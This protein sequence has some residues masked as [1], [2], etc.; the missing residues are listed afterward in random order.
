MLMAPA[1]GWVVTLR[2]PKMSDS[3]RFSIDQ[4][5]VSE[6][7]GAI[8]RLRGAGILPMEPLPDRVLGANISKL[9]LPG[10]GILAGT[11]SGLR[12][13]GDSEAPGGDND[14]FLCINLSGR[15]TASQ[16]DKI[17]TASPGDAVLVSAGDGRFSLTIPTLT[18]VIGLRVARETI[19]PLMTRHDL[20]AMHVIPN[21]VPTI[22]LIA[23]YVNAI[24]K[25]TT[26]I[27]RET[28]RRI[29]GHLH[30]LIALSV[31]PARETIA[32]AE[33]RAVPAAR[34]HAIKVDI[35]ANLF[36]ETLTIGDIAARH[37]VTPRYI[38]KLFE[39][40]GMT[41]TEFV[42]KRRLDHAYHMLQDA[43][44]RDRGIGSIAYAV[45]FGDISYFN[46]TFRRQ[47]NAT[48]SDIREKDKG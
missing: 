30:D 26:P 2:Q 6:R 15:P 42:L 12:I 8:R 24:V 10:L 23:G 38:H 32:L 41:Y 28:S 40:E 47:Y 19:T 4:L 11:L 34:L 37:G 7:A 29:A 17:D 14:F 31:N 22:K 36:D 33:D 3:L 27:D 43:R 1:Q 39:R 21:G 46:R 35:E 44:L 18:R 48:P 45:G 20:L 16:G 13:D 25:M 5:A 9:A